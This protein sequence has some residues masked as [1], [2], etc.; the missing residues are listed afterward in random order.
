MRVVN[1]PAAK[2]R[3]TIDDQEAGIFLATAL[4]EGVN[5]TLQAGPITAQAGKLFNAVA[6]KNGLFFQ[7]WREVQLY[8]V[9]DWLKHPDVEAMRHKEEARLD[10]EIVKSE[11]AIAE[12]R[13]PVPH[14]FKLTPV[15]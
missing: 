8:A 14:V 12:L 3:L 13:A 1:L 4:A 6:A 5:L 7:R 15:D 2:Y 11:K 9:P 10:A